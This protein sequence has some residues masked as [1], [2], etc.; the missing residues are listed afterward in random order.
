MHSSWDIFA[1]AWSIF[2]MPVLIYNSWAMTRQVRRVK[3][4]FEEIALPFNHEAIKRKCLPDILVFDDWWTRN[5]RKIW[6]DC[7]GIN[8]WRLREPSTYLGD[9]YPWHQPEGKARIVNL[10]AL[11]GNLAEHMRAEIEAEIKR[12]IEAGRDISE[13]DG[14]RSGDSEGGE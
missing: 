4:F 12:R 3:A 10:G 7:A 1:L 2:V 14:W 8:S 13:I 11:K 6:R 9:D 5:F